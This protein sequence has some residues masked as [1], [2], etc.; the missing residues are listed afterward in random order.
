M[1][2]GPARMLFELILAAIAIGGFMYGTHW[3]TQVTDQ[4]SKSTDV[5]RRLE[6]LEN[7]NRFLQEKIRDYEAQLKSS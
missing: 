4:G 2:G 3:K 7:Q 1:G 5:M 6:Q